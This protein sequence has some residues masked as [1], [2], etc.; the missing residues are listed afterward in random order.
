M[1][2]FKILIAD[3][4][5][6]ILWSMEKKLSK[7]G[8]DVVVATNGRE[9]VEKYSAGHIDL[10]LMDYMMPVMN[11]L[12]ALNE[13]RKKDKSAMVII[14]TAVNDA[15]AAV[16][17]MKCGALDYIIKTQN[18][19]QLLTSVDNALETIISRQQTQANGAVSGCNN[20]D[21]VYASEKMKNLISIV[22]KVVVSD[23]ATLLLQGESGT[24]KNLISRAIHNGSSRSNRLFVEVDCSSLSSHLLE[25]ELFGHEKGSFTD[26][27]L[28]KQGLCEIAEGGTIFLDEIGEMDINIQAKLLKF[29]EEKKFRRVGGTKDIHVDVRIIAATNKD[30]ATAV[31]RNEFRSDLYYRLNVIAIRIPPLRDRKD[32]IM[33]L[34]MHFLN[35]YS[36]KSGKS[37]TSIPYDV[38]KALFEHDWPGNIRELK[39]VI[40][41]GVLLSSG[42]SLDKDA[43]FYESELT[44][45]VDEKKDLAPMFMESGISL[46]KV[47]SNIIEQA[48]HRSEGNQSQA[49]R[50]LNIGRDCLRRKMKKYGLF[51]RIDNDDALLIFSAACEKGT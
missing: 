19:E 46:E 32:D 5:E 21:I 28:Q 12:D 10:V 48:L 18:P 37:I 39:N 17:A 41:R 11:G 49:A 23:T 35:I 3:D 31:K 38:E 43:L 42:Q 1:N 27:K 9:A 25:S 26:A 47:E 7:K 33:P 22:S 13:I 51:D 44:N 8:F 15:E 24:G 16:K 6:L 29:I 50:L 20:A 34:A 40:E 2:K 14:I 36:R 30:L 4:E 45:H